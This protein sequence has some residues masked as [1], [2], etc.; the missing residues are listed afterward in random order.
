MHG[1]PWY[2]PM[3]EQRV[4]RFVE[5]YLQARAETGEVPE[6]VADVAALRRRM[7]AWTAYERTA[8]LVHVASAASTR[9]SHQRVLPCLRSTLAAHLDREDG[10]DG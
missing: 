8:M 7:H 6:A 9:V 3:D 10:A 4:T 5:C 2:V 1:G